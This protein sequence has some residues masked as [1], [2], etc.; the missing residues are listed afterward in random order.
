MVYKVE[1]TKDGLVRLT[2]LNLWT[3]GECYWV[4]ERDSFNPEKYQTH[5]YNWTRATFVDPG[6]YALLLSWGVTL[7]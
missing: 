7:P 5:L 6:A 2:G 4:H 3:G 1:T